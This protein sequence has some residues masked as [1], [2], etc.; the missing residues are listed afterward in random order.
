MKILFG[1]IFIF[2]LFSS[3]IFAE[4][5]DDSYLAIRAYSNSEILQIHM[6]V[7]DPIGRRRGYESFPIPHYIKEFSGG[8]AEELPSGDEEALESDGYSYITFNHGPV[9]KGTYSITF[10]GI[11][12][13][14]LSYNISAHD[15]NN[16]YNGL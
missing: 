7:T 13:T 12:D 5:R 16:V 9:S 4:N 14:S 15:V 2:N 6:V 3:S 11:S 1:F 8:Y 10:Y